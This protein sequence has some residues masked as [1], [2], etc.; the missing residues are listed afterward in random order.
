MKSADRIDRDEVTMTTSTRE[1]DSFSMGT[2]SLLLIGP[3]EKRR[4][5]VARAFAGSQATISCELSYYPS[6]DD[7]PGLLAAGYDAVIIDLDC[8]PEQAFEVIENLCGHNSSITVM[9]HSGKSDPTM[10]VHCMR[11]GA[12]E[13]LTEPVLPGAAS[14]ALIRAA[15]RRDEGRRQ[16]TAAGKLLV[17]AG[18]KGGC[19]VTTIASN[20]AVSLAAHEKVLLVDLDLMLG[21]VALT[22]GIRPGFTVLDAFDNLNRLDSD[23]LMGL[24]AKHDS[25]LVVLG[26]PDQIPALQPSGNGL[27]RLLR[28]AREEFAYV[29]VDA[30]SCPIKTCESLFE[31]A[32][33][34]YLVSQV[35]VADLR[36]ANR[37]V[38]RFFNGPDREK[39][40]IVLNRYDSRNLDIDDEAVAK[41]LLQPAKWRVP[42][43]FVAAQRAQ[44]TG[45]PLSTQKSAL[46]RSIHDMAAAA[47]GRVAACTKKKKFG[48]FGRSEPD[49]LAGLKQWK[50]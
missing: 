37:F 33:T 6:P 45:V 44:N 1:T 35:S 15:V 46:A 9:V 11:A 18:A 26:A 5:A 20:F 29:V 8:N 43:D 40:N 39:L 14:E 38:M 42:S 12:R 48:L 3:E 4:T 21:D 17:F 24:T 19:G 10:L 49:V 13:F 16:R 36:S 2:L 7:L 34:V 31:M 25:G 47:S 27:D 23:F 28:V 30:G 32:T 41:A 50:N 22:L